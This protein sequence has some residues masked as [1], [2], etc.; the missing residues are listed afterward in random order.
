MKYT[1][2][3]Q[4]DCGVADGHGVKYPDNYERPEKIEASTDDEAL[5]GAYKIAVYLSRDHL[6]NPDT[7]FTTVLLESL[8]DSTGRIITQELLI[9]EF[10]KQQKEGK[11]FIQ[12]SMLEH[13]LRL[14]KE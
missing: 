9:S 6:S 3:F 2:I 7:N 1:A 11:L 10:P 8:I 14:S 4:I 13:L 5:K 12:C